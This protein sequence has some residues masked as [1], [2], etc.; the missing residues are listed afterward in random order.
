[1]GVQIPYTFPTPKMDIKQI[2]Q[3]SDIILRILR[4]L[5]ESSGVT[6]LELFERFPHCGVSAGVPSPVSQEQFQGH[7]VRN[8]RG[9]VTRTQTSISITASTLTLRTSERKRG[10]LP[11]CGDYQQVEAPIFLWL[12]PLS[13]DWSPHLRLTCGPAGNRTTTNYSTG[14]PL[15]PPHTCSSSKPLEVTWSTQVSHPCIQPVT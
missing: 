11:N 12:A 10:N 5:T 2:E 1:M 6:K 13:F 4:F 14:T 7:F 8:F 9:K 15:A 3:F